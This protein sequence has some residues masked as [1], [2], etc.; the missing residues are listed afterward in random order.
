MG[1]CKKKTKAFGDKLLKANEI[2][3]NSKLI[4]SDIS[5]EQLNNY[6][7]AYFPKTFDIL[8]NEL[9]RAE[10]NRWNAFHYLKGWQYNKNLDKKAKKH[11]CLMPIE[12]FKTDRIKNTYK[13][14]LLSLLNIPKYLAYSGYEIIEK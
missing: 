9:A 4:D 8:F 12:D 7:S 6:Q 13:Y 10:K 5:E 1:L 11:D 3:F 14:D 2:V